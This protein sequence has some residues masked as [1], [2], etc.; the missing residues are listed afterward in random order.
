MVTIVSVIILAIRIEW[1]RSFKIGSLL[2]PQLEISLK[3]ELASIMVLI[4][5]YTS[6]SWNAFV[7]EKCCQ[8]ILK[9]GV[10]LEMEQGSNAKLLFNFS[11]FSSNFKLI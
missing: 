3:V 1:K 5:I 7:Y 6:H 11:I 9:I 8:N 10:P 2:A 4:N